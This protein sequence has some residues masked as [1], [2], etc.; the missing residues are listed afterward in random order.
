MEILDN[1]IG[2]F[3]CVPYCPVGAIKRNETDN[4]AYIEHDEC[5][6][7]GVCKNSG[8]CPVQA[9]YQNELIWPDFLK[10]KW[11][12][13]VYV[14]PE[15]NI[16]GRGTDEMKTNDVTGRFKPGFIGVGVELGRPSTGARFEDVE[17]V[18]RALAECGVAFE[19]NNPLT[20]FIDV[21]TG[22]FLEEWQ[23]FPLD[24]RFRKTKVMT[25]IIEAITRD[26]KM[27]EVIESLK[28]VSK[29]IDTVMSVEVITK[30]SENGDIPIMRVL[31]ENG[32]KHYING[33]TNIGLG[34]PRY[35]F[36]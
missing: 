10:A 6:E 15:T 14:H 5:V 2:C 29:E 17:K 24:E 19:K 22:M 23:G 1:C 18:A 27:L 25:V 30:C 36:Q 20:S 11:S 33:K 8:I 7:C 35:N 13:V 28:A 34:K 4:V 32:I 3:R 26:S 16:Q 21:N 9:I 31:D 12:S